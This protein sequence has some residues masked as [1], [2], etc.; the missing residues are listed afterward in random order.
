[1]TYIVIGICLAL[2]ATVVII[3]A[4]PIGMGIEARRNNTHSKNEK[5][6]GHSSINSEFEK[7]SR[8][9]NFIFSNSIDFIH[10]FFNFERKINTSLIS[11][12]VQLLGRNPNLNKLFTKIAD[13]GNLI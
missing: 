9:K 3:A 2:L 12:S 5:E 11:K 1:M 8:H 7:K 4:K 10:E 13:E 6:D